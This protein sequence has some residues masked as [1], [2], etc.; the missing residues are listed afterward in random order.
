VIIFSAVFPAAHPCMQK[1]MTNHSYSEPTLNY[2]H[3]WVYQVRS[4]IGHQYLSLMSLRIRRASHAGCA[5]TSQSGTRIHRCRKKRRQ[6]NTSSSRL[7]AIFPDSRST[8]SRTCSLMKVVV[9]EDGAGGSGGKWG[10]IRN[11]VVHVGF[12]CILR[13]R[14]INWANASERHSVLRHEVLG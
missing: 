11:R 12:Y 6:T 10:G 8:G 3:Q 4:L 1:R 9:Q 5:P 14:C 7:S 13:W 2:V